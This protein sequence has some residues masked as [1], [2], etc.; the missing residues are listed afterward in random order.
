[1]DGRHII[2]FDGVCGLCDRAVQFVLPRDRRGRF[3][4]APLQ[5]AIAV[6]KLAPFG[7]DAS[8]LDSVFVLA[9]ARGSSPR[10]LARG[11]AILFILREL[12]GAWGVLARLAGV[13][14]TVVIDWFY[15]RVARSRYRLFGKLDACRLP[16]AGERERF[17][18]GSAAPASGPR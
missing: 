10:L 17:L 8:D 12:G 11:R 6:E 2:F 13:A 18:D 16:A 14:P 7:V 3:L 4:F 9:D 15:R 1:V 5:S